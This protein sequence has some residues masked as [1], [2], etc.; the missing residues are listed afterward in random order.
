MT[1]FGGLP[2]PE[3]FFELF[4]I[5]L[6]KDVSVEELL[7]FIVESYHWDACFVCPVQN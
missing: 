6:D 1:R 5:A 4:G 3:R 7:F 2:L